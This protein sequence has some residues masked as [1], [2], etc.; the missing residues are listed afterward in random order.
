MKKLLMLLLVFAVSSCAELNK[1]ATTSPLNL[2]NKD[3]GLG[4]REAL[5][6]G[7]KLQ[8]NKL[9]KK[10]GFYKNELVKILLP[11]ELQKVDETL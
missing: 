5:N 3:I 9:K 11:N 6:Q 8:V 10:D 1:I 4:L 7:V 2:S